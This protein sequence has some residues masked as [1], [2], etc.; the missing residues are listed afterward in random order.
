[1]GS[2][3]GQRK[4][5]RHRVKGRMHTHGIE[6]ESLV[7][8]FFLHFFLFV[9]EPWAFLLPPPLHSTVVERLLHHFGS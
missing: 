1:M 6:R 3:S 9:D 4:S 2:M 7:W 5:E 8:C